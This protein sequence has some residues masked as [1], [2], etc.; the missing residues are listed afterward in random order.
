MSAVLAIVAQIPLS[1]PLSTRL[2]A[3][4]IV[5]VVLLS[6]AAVLYIRWVQLKNEPLDEWWQRRLAHGLS[7]KSR[8]AAEASEQERRAAAGEAPPQGGASPAGGAT[9]GG[10]E[11]GSR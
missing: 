11:D 6:T 7:A 3:L 4:A 8:F 9:A 5:E 2:I 1:P 10:L